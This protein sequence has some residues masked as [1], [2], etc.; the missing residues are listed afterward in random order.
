M[1]E[2]HVTEELLG[3]LAKAVSAVQLISEGDK[4][5]KLSKDFY[6]YSP[7]LKRLLEEKRAEVIVLVDSVESLKAVVSACYQAAVPI[8]L[9]GG[10]TGN[11]GQC[12]PLYGGVV[13]DLSPLNRFS[14]SDQGVLC[15][16]D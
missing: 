8:T 16:F 2:S 4:V 12:V 7:V 15:A 6:W 10:G 14:V 9:R 11:Y 13:I 1:Q 3:Q 5:E